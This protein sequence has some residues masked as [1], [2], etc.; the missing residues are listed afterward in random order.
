MS[1]RMAIIKKQ[2][3]TTISKDMEN[4]EPLCTIN[5]NKNWYSHYGL[6]YGGFSKF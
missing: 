4:E 1:V 6:E 2:E 3:I 5:R